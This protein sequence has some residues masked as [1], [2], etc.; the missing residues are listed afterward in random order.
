MDKRTRTDTRMRDLSNPHQKST[1]L[2]A[3]HRC[4]CV[5]DGDTQAFTYL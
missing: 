1:D 2:V 5:Q 4:V 3:L